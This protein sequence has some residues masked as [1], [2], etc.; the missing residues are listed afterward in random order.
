MAPSAGSI[1]GVGKLVVGGKT[2]FMEFMSLEETDD[3]ITMWMILG[4]PSKGEQRR[5]PF[6][7][8]SVRETS[9]VFD[10]P[11]NGF[12][13]RISY[14]LNSD[15]N[16]TCTLSGIKAGQEITDFYDFAK[17]SF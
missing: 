12:P 6:K 17:M 8:I 7:L 4:S 15:K 5:V 9:A 2:A 10:L 13:S 11:T 3:G 1:Q 14:E 16:L